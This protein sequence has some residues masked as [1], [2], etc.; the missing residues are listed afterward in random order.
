M[1][2]IMLGIDED[3]SL[4]TWTSELK[5]FGGDFAPVPVQD[6]SVI[7]CLAQTDG[8]GVQGTNDHG[9]LLGLSGD[10]HPQ[11]FRLDGYR[12]LTGN[13]NA[14][15]FQITNVGNVDGV[16]VS[17]HA[18]R[19]ISG[20]S[21]PIDGY[22]LSLSYT[23]SRY[24][25]PTNAKLGEHIHQID[26]ALLPHGAL[27]GY[28]QLSTAVSD[29]VYPIG[30]TFPDGYIPLDYDGYT[31]SG[32]VYDELNSDFV[33]QP[34]YYQADNIQSRG[35]RS[36][37][38]Y[39]FLVSVGDGYFQRERPVYEFA[40]EFDGYHVQ[41]NWHDLGFFWYGTER[42]IFKI[43]FQGFS[44][45]FPDSNVDSTLI[46][47]DMMFAAD[48]VI[49]SSTHNFLLASLQFKTA[50]GTSS[51]Y[52]NNTGETQSEYWINNVGG[53]FMDNMYY[54]NAYYDN[55]NSNLV[56]DIIRYTSATGGNGT[57]IRVGC[58]MEAWSN[59]LSALIAG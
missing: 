45:V 5:D 37:D 53:D 40:W 24:P 44:T 39:S 21:D 23:P 58:R 59:K 29:T 19:H 8:Y 11:Y 42:R 48:E 4:V 9:D 47:I 30:Y 3:Q 17:S 28:V 18:S 22:Q 54:V 49:A 38:G 43:P 46:K 6:V 31:Q 25:A 41:E 50:N 15:G 7:S 35:H 57:K 34:P 20:G 1:K 2:Y 12:A 36:D 27:D 55:L 16:D 13:L 32:F 51:E 10:D 14:G 56:L 52:S 26:L 33:L